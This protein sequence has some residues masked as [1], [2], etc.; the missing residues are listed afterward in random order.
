[1]LL[2]NLGHEV[3]VTHDPAAAIAACQVAP[4]DVFILDIGLPGMGGFALAQELR[5]C[6]NGTAAAFIAL[7]GYGGTDDRQRAEKT[8]R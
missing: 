7:K 4:I 6:S 3:R 1:M 5:A 8:A 2:E